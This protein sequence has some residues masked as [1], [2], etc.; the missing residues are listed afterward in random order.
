MKKI[1]FLTFLILG[2]LAYG[3]A[4][5][6]FRSVS[7]SVDD[8]AEM[9]SIPSGKL[10]NGKMVYR[11]DTKTI[12]IYDVNTWKDT[13]VGAD[14]IPS[15]YT[16][17]SGLNL[18]GTEFSVDT[19][20]PVFDNFD[21]DGS[22]TNVTAGTNTT[23]TGTGTSGDP[24][25]VN[26]LGEEY[27]AGAGLN[28][29]GNAFSVNNGEVVFIDGS[30]PFG[31]IQ[32][33]LGTSAA[34][35]ALPD[36]PTGI[37]R[38]E[39]P[40]DVVAGEDIYP[41]NV[42]VSGTTTKTLT[43]TL[44]NGSTIS[45]TFTDDGSGGSGDG[46]DY[47][48]SVTQSGGI[49]T[50]NVQNQTNPTFDIDAYL[51]TKNYSTG[52]HTTNTNDFPVAGTL[53]GD[54]LTLDIPNQAD[55]VIDLSGLRADGS[56]TIIIQGSNVLINGSGTSGDPY[57]VSSTSSGG[58]ITDHGALT[59]LLDD[60]H[61]QYMTQTESDA[62]YIQSEVDGST[63][64]EIQTLS[65]TGSTIS[66]SNGGGSVTDTD[67]QLTNEQV[68]DYV[69]A[70]FSGNTETG[71]TA[72][73]QDGDNTIDLVAA[74]TSP[75]NELQTIT[76]SGNTVTLSNGGGSFTDSDTDTQ[77][78]D[79]QV[80]DKVGA[81]VSGNSE[82]G[83]TVTYN[84]GTGKLDF[85]SSGITET[86]GSW[87]PTLIGGGNEV[88]FTYTALGEWFRQ[89]D[90]VTF[91]IHIYNINDISGAATTSL[92]IDNWPFSFSGKWVLPIVV[93][94]MSGDSSYR[95]FAEFSTGNGSAAIIN[96]TSLVPNVNGTLDNASF[97]NGELIL[98][99]T[100]KI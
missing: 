37:N 83:I 2:A 20:D 53:T 65:K 79:E 87:S 52:A 91:Y 19:S 72:T 69:G 86:S 41:T 67:T 98:S 14:G 93:R 66:L 88:F 45:T 43:I 32:I 7:F 29:T 82:T 3:Q 25:V 39:I 54:N 46:N 31:N 48:T 36:P 8:A 85:S 49:L 22:G 28:L 13:G 16:A 75:T 24:Y 61:P 15:N 81:M 10:S 40:T 70:M 64:N 78:T 71:I 42:T 89:G 99:G 56:E 12:W 38:V 74:D 44:S 100:I 94:G 51:A 60:D 17:G 95:L 26:S 59:G 21:K 55:P 34:L 18:T 57:V 27:T 47:L 35:D 73:Y 4:D 63:T 80:Q 9:N 30:S 33:A 5:P 11:R 90:L 92:K 97:T 76:K 84:D 77:L 68:S 96:Q 58:G 23:V 50:F 62:R 1:I 6:E